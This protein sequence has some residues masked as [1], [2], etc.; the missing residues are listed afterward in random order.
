MPTYKFVCPKCGETKEEILKITAEK[1]E[2]PECEKCKVKMQKAWITPTG[3]FIL[4]G[5]GWFNKGGY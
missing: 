3:G 5:T 4:K 2:F 1:E